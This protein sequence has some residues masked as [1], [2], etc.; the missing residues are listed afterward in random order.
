MHGCLFSVMHAQY[1]YIHMLN[2]LNIQK[3][4]CLVQKNKIIY[5]PTYPHKKN[6]SRRMANKHFFEFRPDHIP[7]G[8]FFCSDSEHFT[9]L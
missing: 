1:M 7:R 2:I 5:L 3:N 9:I 8:H 6:L 4:V